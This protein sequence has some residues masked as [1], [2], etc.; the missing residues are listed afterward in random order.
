MSI[1]ITKGKKNRPQ[2]VCVYGPEGVGKTEL[3]AS[4]PNPLF[5]D[6]EGGSDH[7]DVE[8]WEVNS[9]K[10]IREAIKFLLTEEHDYKSAILDTIDWVEKRD[11]QE[12]CAKYKV[13]SIEKIEGGYG[14]GYT[15]L[16][17]SLMSFLGELDKVRA[18]GI[19]VVLL[20]HSKVLKFEDPELAAAFDRYQL[21]LEKKTSMLV[22]EWVDALLFANYV[23]NVTDK[24]GTFDSKRGVGGK[25]RV[26]HTERSA[27]FDA[28]NRHGLTGSVEMP[29]DNPSV[30]IIEPI[31][32]PLCAENTHKE[33]AKTAPPEETSDADEAKLTDAIDKAGGKDAVIAFLKSKKEEMPMSDK[34][35]ARV[36]DNPQGFIDAVKKFNKEAA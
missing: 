15:I 10:E 14:K 6:A 33:P 5:I 20:A 35:R 19:H 24:A 11:A 16:E 17:E 30:H 27:A 3:A 9:M 12:L 34:F 29:K 8:R 31:F 21:K 2:K 36:L 13:D 22:K 23:T 7:I 26:L 1:K 32:G 28:K 18:K 4:L 25:K